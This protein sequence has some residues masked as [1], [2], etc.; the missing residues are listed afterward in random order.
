MAQFTVSLK[1]IRIGWQVPTLLDKIVSFQNV[2]YS[3]AKFIFSILETIATSRFTTEN[4]FEFEKINWINL[5]KLS[6]K[7]QG[8]SLPV[9][10]WRLTLLKVF[11]V[12]EKPINICCDFV[13][14]NK[15]KINNINRSNFEKPLGTA[16]LAKLIGQLM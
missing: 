8:C 12:T 1:F 6:K 14:G 13:S 5:R 4:N 7:V 15:N 2:F 10:T 3:L 16:L 9:Y 11:R